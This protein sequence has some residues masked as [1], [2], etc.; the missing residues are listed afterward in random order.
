[1][2]ID[3]SLPYHQIDERWPIFGC[4][5]YETY[6]ERY[7][8]KGFFHK[9]VPDDVKDSYKTVEHL[10]AL[11]W[12][13]YPMY[14]EALNKVLRT[15]ELAIKKKCELL[16]I[17]IEKV[18]NK[19]ISKPKP[20]V[21]LIGEICDLEPNKHQSIFLNYFRD[22][23]NSLMHP[24]HHH[25]AGGI[26][27]G[28]ILLAVNIINILFAPENI[29]IS[30]EALKA[31]KQKEL[32]LFENKPIILD[33]GNKPLLAHSMSFCDAFDNGKNQ[34]VLVYIDLVYHLTDEI[35]QKQGY[36]KTI[37]YEIVNPVVN[38]EKLS[39]IDLN[40]GLPISV[41]ITVK[42]E[43][44][45]ES[46]NFKDYLYSLNTGPPATYNPYLTNRMHDIGDGI[47]RFH[48]KHYQ[49]LVFIP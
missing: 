10:I 37:A 45:K 25:Y 39:G 30:L 7:L 23:R 1:M 41:S 47:Q 38:L 5:N 35:R 4:N 27:F 28:K 32:K 40:T 36:P 13:H 48:Y 43:H 21:D 46:K 9:G 20:L 17:P 29:I 2:S 42:E 15:F 14:D 19:N 6:L 8:V 12:Y 18:N 34:I 11:A 33:S 44:L 26:M 24:S 22:L 49:S 16:S 31:K 3:T